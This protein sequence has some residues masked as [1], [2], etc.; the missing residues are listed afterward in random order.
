MVFFSEILCRCPICSRRSVGNSW[1]G[2]FGLSDLF[3]LFYFHLIQ[4][5]NCTV[6]IVV[7]PF[8]F[9]NVY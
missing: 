3:F 6:L 1:F 4:L 2:M 8:T 5:S 7:T 9:R